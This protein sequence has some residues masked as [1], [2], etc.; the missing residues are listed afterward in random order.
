MKRE[1]QRGDGYQGYSTDLPLGRYPLVQGRMI[2]PAA[3]YDFER[4][5]AR[6]LTG[7]AAIDTETD[8]VLS[9]SETDRCAG[10][11]ELAFDDNGD[12]YFGTG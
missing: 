2:I 12:V 9:Y 6:A 4:G 1:Q 3:W 11:T 5:S 7:L 8:C 10:A